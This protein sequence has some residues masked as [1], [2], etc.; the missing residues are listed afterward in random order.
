MCPDCGFA[1]D[2]RTGDLTV[3]RDRLLLEAQWLV[4]ITV[5]DVHKPWS[6]T[7]SAHDQK[8]LVSAPKG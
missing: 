7:E 5:I 4:S 3:P 2:L 6:E 8:R 1:P